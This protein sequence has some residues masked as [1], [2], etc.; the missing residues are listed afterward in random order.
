MRPNL[1]KSFLGKLRAK[2]DRP[3]RPLATM[4]CI[5]PPLSVLWR[6]HPIYPEKSMASTRVNCWSYFIKCSLHCD[7]LRANQN[8]ANLVF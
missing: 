2:T 6:K 4:I 7:K 8:L 5:A 3:Y 1:R